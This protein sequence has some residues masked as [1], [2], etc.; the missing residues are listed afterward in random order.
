MVSSNDMELTKFDSI[1]KAT[2]SIGTGEGIIMYARKNCRD[3][4]KRFNGGSEVSS[5]EVLFTNWC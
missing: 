1:R 4:V 2:K 3:F 5:T